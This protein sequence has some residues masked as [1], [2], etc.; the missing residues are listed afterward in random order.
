ML[1]ALTRI[2]LVGAFLVAQAGGIAHE[3]WHDAAA[4]SHA[5]ADAGS[6]GK[7]PGKNPLCD[8]HTALASVLGAIHGATYSVDVTASVDSIFIA[9][10]IPAA[11]FSA[12]VP[13]PRGPPALL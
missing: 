6:S 3:I 9:A 13:Q 4:A 8:F 2:L 5:G 10:D 7:S 12:L 1:R 11:R